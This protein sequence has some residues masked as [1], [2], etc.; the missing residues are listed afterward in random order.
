LSLVG[1]RAKVAAVKAWL[2]TKDGTRHSLQGTCSIG[3][4]PENSIVLEDKRVSRRHA[5]IYAHRDGNH[6]LM[7]FGSSN[8]ILLNKER[9]SAPTCLQD[10]DRLVISDHVFIYHNKRVAA[11][12]SAPIDL[13]VDAGEKTERMPQGVRAAERGFV[14]LAAGGKIQF[15]TEPARR[16]LTKYFPEFEGAALPAGLRAWALKQSR[17]ASPSAAEERFPSPMVVEKGTLRLVVQYERDERQELLTLA[18]HMAG[19]DAAALA[20]LELTGREVEV[21]RWVVQGKTNSDVAAIL[22]LSPRTVNKHLEHL[23]QK[24]GV[25]TRTAAMLRGLELLGSPAGAESH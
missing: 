25:E 22:G 12:P 14:F 20:A 5:L 23:Y 15:C 16:W 19:E 7:D 2:E 13:V 21:L 8:G 3:R 11:V 6:W 9:V 4:L 10:E 24:L 18:E 1:F 17:P